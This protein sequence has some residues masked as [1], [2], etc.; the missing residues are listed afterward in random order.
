MAKFIVEK[1][2]TRNVAAIGVVGSMTFCALQ[3]ECGILIV[4]TATDGN[5]W[6]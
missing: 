4:P 2:L 6:G 5:G 1:M 3:P